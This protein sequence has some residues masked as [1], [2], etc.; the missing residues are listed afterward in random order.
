[1][2]RKPEFDDSC[3]CGHQRY[4]HIAMVDSCT[5]CDECQSF[6]LKVNFRTLTEIC[7]EISSRVPVAVAMRVPRTLGADIVELLAP[8]ASLSL[9]DNP[10][11]FGRSF[12]IDDELKDNEFAFGEE[13]VAIV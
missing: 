10:T 2:I 5:F 7:V 11:I 13:R 3:K 12:L 8:H 9:R 4:Q 1:M 6:K